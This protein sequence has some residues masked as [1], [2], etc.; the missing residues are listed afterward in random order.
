MDAGGWTDTWFARHGAVC[1]FAVGPGAEVLA[2]LSPAGVGPGNRG[3]QVRLSVADFGDSYTYPAEAP[4][5]H[6]PLLEA[7][8][9]H[10]APAGRSLEVATRSAVPAGSSLGTSASVVVALIA[11]LQELSGPS[12]VTS[13]TALAQAAHEVETVHLLRQSGVQD[14]VAAAFGGANL[15]IIDPY[16][17]FEVRPLGLARG[18]ADALAR[19]VV[20]VYLSAFHDSS[21]VHETVIERLAGDQTEAERLMRPLRASA[22]R[23]ASA[24]AAGDLDAYGAA[25]VANTEAQAALHPS[26]VNPLARHAITVAERCGALGWKVNGAGGPGGTVTLLAPDDPGALLKE[27]EAVS[28]L[29]VLHLK[30]ATAGARVVDRG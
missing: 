23:A 30:P 28:D 29:K 10:W 3:N 17:S 1:H 7:A 19:R 24:L 14:Q 4:P 22:T 16:P 5:G 25:M 18:V 21:A 15:V 8:I 26:L 12:A 6:H 27:L 20:T 9:R 2:R 11:A 13:P